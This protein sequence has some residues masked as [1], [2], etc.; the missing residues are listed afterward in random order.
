MQYFSPDVNSLLS[1]PADF[2]IEDM[3]HA[4]INPQETKDSS[5]HL[6]DPH[7]RCLDATLTPLPTQTCS[8][9]SPNRH[10]RS[11]CISRNVSQ[12]VCL[13]SHPRSVYH[14]TQLCVPHLIKTKGSIVNVSSVNGQRSV[15]IKQVA[16][17]LIF[18]CMLLRIETHCF[19]SPSS[20]ECWPTACPNLPLISLQVVLL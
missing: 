16:S 2:P 3:R 18:L 8:T 7:H 15:R 12:Y 11:K 1:S 9:C 10:L 20:L 5:K 19:S 14:L 4:V 6:W 17:C 13:V